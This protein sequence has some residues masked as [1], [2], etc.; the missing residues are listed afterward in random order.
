LKI[1]RLK[2]CSKE[3]YLAEADKSLGL[4]HHKSECSYDEASFNPI[5]SWIAFEQKSR[6]NDGTSPNK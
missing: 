4:Q 5:L 3:A 6:G 1:V 2:D